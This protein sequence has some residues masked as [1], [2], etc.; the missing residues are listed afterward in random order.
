M[1]PGSDGSAA[2]SNIYLYAG[3][4]VAAAALLTVGAACRAHRRKPHG[5][6]DAMVDA[7]SNGKVAYEHTTP[8]GPH[9]AHSGETDEQRSPG[10]D[11]AMG[12]DLASPQEY[13][14]D[15]EGELSDYDDRIRP[16]SVRATQVAKAWAV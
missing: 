8:D 10:A 7:F 9:N 4:A 14:W 12:S 3:I 13:F 6:G 2:P 15:D 5:G 11:L 1:Q 16:V